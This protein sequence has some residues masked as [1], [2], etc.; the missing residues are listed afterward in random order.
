MLATRVFFRPRHRD[1][2]LELSKELDN[3]T[4]VREDTDDYGRTS[5]REY[6]KPLMSV[7]ELMTLPDDEVVIMTPNCKPVRT[8]RFTWKTFPSAKA[9]DCPELP[10]HKPTVADD[11]VPDQGVIEQVAEQAKKQAAVTETERDFYR[12]KEQQSQELEKKRKKKKSA[13]DDDERK[14]KVRSVIDVHD[15]DWNVPG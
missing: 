6:G 13:D 10:E 11:V 15:D 4:L 2:A 14:I 12:E 1:T 7:S 3:T 9:Y 5:I 8:K